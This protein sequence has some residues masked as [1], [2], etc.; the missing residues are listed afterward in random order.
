MGARPSAPIPRA[1]FT[2]PTKYVAFDTTRAIQ[3]TT[4][5]HTVLGKVRKWPHPLLVADRPWEPRIDNG[6]PNIVYDPSRKDAPFRLWYDTC[7]EVAAAH[8]CTARDTKALLYAESEDGITWSKPELGQVS[9]RGSKRNNIVLVGTHGL[10]VFRDT[11]ATAAARYKAVGQMHERVYK[12]VRL[13]T[14][15]DRARLAAAL[16]QDGESLRLAHELRTGAGELLGRNDVLMRMQPGGLELTSPSQVR[17]HSYLYVFAS[18]LCRA[19]RA[20]LPYRSDLPSDLT[21][22][23]DLTSLRAGRW[24]LFLCRRRSHSSN[25][26]WV[27]F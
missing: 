12:N 13:E 9:W 4:N 26:Q 3:H 2:S 18:A 22:H 6:Y 11:R 25:R 19:Y 10:G 1:D 14:E 7:I 8:V 17:M 20:D 24:R 21:S 5:T 15:A 16:R 27:A 23:I